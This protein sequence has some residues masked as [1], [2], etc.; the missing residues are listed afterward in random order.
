MAV[1]T[2][3]DNFGEELKKLEAERN[4]QYI[5]TY[6]SEKEQKERENALK[7]YYKLG[8]KSRDIDILIKLPDRITI[9][10]REKQLLYEKRI[11]L[12]LVAGIYFSDDP[13]HEQIMKNLRLDYS[14]EDLIDILET[15]IDKIKENPMVKLILSY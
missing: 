6:D 13:I 14:F 9:S 1:A 8:S 15:I 2:F 3:I 5:L 4:E 11:E 12:L 7:K 10:E